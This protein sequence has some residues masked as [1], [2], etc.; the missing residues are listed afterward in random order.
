MQRDNGLGHGEVYEAHQG[1]GR[2]T[3]HMITN[4]WKLSVRMGILTPNLN[5]WMAG[6][7]EST[8]TRLRRAHLVRKM[9]Q[10]GIQLAGIQ[11][12]HFDTEAEILQWKY[13]LSKRGYGMEA[14]VASRRGS[15]VVL[16]RQASWAATQ[17]HRLEPRVL[18]VTPRHQTEQVRVVSAHMHH[19]LSVQERQ[20]QRLQQYLQSQPDLPTL[21]L[22]DHN[23]ILTPKVDSRFVRGEEVSGVQS[24]RGAKVEAL[25]KMA[26]VDGWDL[27]HAVAATPPPRYTFGHTVQGPKRN[28]RQ[29]DRVHVPEDMTPSVAGAYTILSGCDHRGVVIQLAPPSVEVGR[30]RQKFPKAMLAD[31]VAMLRLHERV[32][33]LQVE[34]PLEWWQAAQCIVR[35]EGARL[36]RSQSTRGFF[37]L[38]AAV[39]A[40]SPWRVVRAGW[41]YL[42]QQ[43]LCPGTT[44]DAYRALASFLADER[45]EATHQRS[46]D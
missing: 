17:S 7:Q 35:E 24:A 43:G 38:E 31:E 8:D 21:L 27:V 4:P 26:M 19:I 36:A 18:I 9:E 32:Y 22:M 11:E 15:A 6:K 44:G 39:R 42:E 3:V 28:L 34:S 41:E 20:W 5:G 1:G 30:P 37:Q 45:L 10:H 29:I 2:L 23:S 25:R 14:T 16:W 33:S 40:S 12:T 46:M 13:W